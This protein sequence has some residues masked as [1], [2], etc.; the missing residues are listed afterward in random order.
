[1]LETLIVVGIILIICF[2]A[3]SWLAGSDAPYVATKNIRLKKLLQELRIKRGLI[4]YELG[5]GDGRVVFEAAKMGSDAFGIE[6]SWLRV[7][8]SRYRAKK[9]NLPNAKFIHGNIFEQDFF[10][11]DIV[12]I[13]LLPKGVSKLEPIL[14]KKLKKGTRIVTQTFHFPNW[15]PIKKLLVVDKLSPNTLLGKGLVEGDFWIYRI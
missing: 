2:L 5:S 15:K 6:Q 14:Q 7:L 1:M 10:N 4:F 11:A 9:L 8:L 12:F 13:F 3:L